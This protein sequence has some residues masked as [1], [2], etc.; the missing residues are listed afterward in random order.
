M[1]RLGQYR[2]IR[3]L[4][5][6]AMGVVWLAEHELLQVHRAVK[7]MPERLAG[8]EGFRERFL[9]EARVLARLQH[10]HIV[11]VHDMVVEGDS[12]AIAMD[13]V[14]PDGSRSQSLLDLVG[15]G[16]QADAPTRLQSDDVARIMGET[17]SAIAFAHEKGVIHRDIKAANVLV[18][19]GRSEE[20]R[21]G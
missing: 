11:P 18:G 8:S 12:Y 21:V 19:P 16:T 10:P 14:S 3:Q 17:C 20:R 1:D 15:D 7:V 4:G 6:G 13:F 5:A 2:I 9:Q